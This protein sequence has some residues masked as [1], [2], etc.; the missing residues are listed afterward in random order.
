M[1]LESMSD[2]Q[3]L[4]QFCQ[5]GNQ[6]AFE[7]LVRRHGSMVTAAARRIVRNPTDVEDC[8]QAVF[9][10]LAR[11][12]ASLH[13][14]QSVA[15]WLHQVALNVSMRSRESAFAQQ[16]REHEAD[17]IGARDMHGSDKERSMEMR[18][19]LDGGLSRL[20]EKYR[21]AIVLHHLEGQTVEATARALGKPVGTA[22]TWIRQGRDVLRQDLERSGVVL[23]AGSL[24]TAL[25]TDGSAVLSS[26]SISRVAQTAARA[27]VN[28]AAANVSPRVAALSEEEL[29][30]MSLQ[31]FSL[32]AVVLFCLLLLGAS[33][34]FAATAET[35][36]NADLKA[37]TTTST[38]APSRTTPTKETSPK[39]P[40]AMVSVEQPRPTGGNDPEIAAL[41]IQL[42]DDAQEVREDAFDNLKDAG[43]KAEPALTVA[44]RH[45]NYDISSAAARL[46]QMRKVQP[47]ID[48]IKAAKPTFTRMEYTCARTGKLA[49]SYR[50]PETLNAPVS[51]VFRWTGFVDK[52][53][54]V[55]ISEQKTGANNE[56]SY[57]VKTVKNEKGHWEEETTTG[58]VIVMDMADED[59]DEIPCDLLELTQSYLEENYFTTCEE[60]VSDGEPV[61]EL[62][63]GSAPVRLSDETVKI[64]NENLGASNHDVLKNP[65]RIVIRVSRNDHMLRSAESFNELGESTGT[66]KVEKIVLDPEFPAGTFDYAFPPGAPLIR[67]GHDFAKDPLVIPVPKPQD[68]KPVR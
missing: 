13:A 41:V 52:S 62:T 64:V 15:G 21:Q 35:P 10:V 44:S 33:L 26:E 56:I 5:D 29:N 8:V 27:V 46:L 59:D 4:R 63:G 37:P 68:E 22:A 11:K 16:C 50:T 47:V 9:I 24:A 18:E 51:E 3:L 58:D 48:K 28:P 45:E 38:P 20:P 7:Q 53:R 55:A 23:S 57:S 54:L 34:G 17:A 36:V 65:A 60:K 6:Y 67:M 66:V 25:S 1:N 2:G 14:R 30:A 32:A 42:G 12:A 49:W 40:A 19:W 43:A 61:Y 39:K 31:K